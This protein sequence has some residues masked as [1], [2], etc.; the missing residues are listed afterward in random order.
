M[1]WALK[2]PLQ[3]SDQFLELK[4]CVSRGFWTSDEHEVTRALSPAVARRTHR[5]QKKRRHFW[6]G[7]AFSKSS[8]F[9]QRFLKQ[10]SSAALLSTLSQQP[11]SAAFLSSVFQQ[12]FSAVFFS[13]L[14]QQPFLAA[15]L[16]CHPQP[17]SCCGH[18]LV[19]SYCHHLAVVRGWWSAIAI[20]L[21][22][23]GVGGQLLTSSCCGQGLVASYWHNLAVVRCWWSAM[24]TFLERTLGNAFGK[25]GFSA[26]CKF[27]FSDIIL[28][29]FFPILRVANHGYIPTVLSAFSFPQK[30]PFYTALDN[31]PVVA[32]DYMG[33]PTV[34]VSACYGCLCPTYF[35]L[36]RLLPLIRLFIRLLKNSLLFCFYGQSPSDAA[37]QFSLS[38]ADWWAI[39]PGV[40]LPK[41]LWAKKLCSQGSLKGCLHGNDTQ[42]I[43]SYI[44]LNTQRWLFHRRYAGC[45]LFTL[46]LLNATWALVFFWN[47]KLPLCF[48][49]TWFYKGNTF[50][51]QG[52]L[53]GLSQVIE[54]N[55]HKAFS[56]GMQSRR[57]AV[58]KGGS[59]ND[60][61]V[62]DKVRA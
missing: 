36:I 24:N 37:P 8:V 48:W 4:I 21:L 7:A 56:L 1:C 62:L 15:F 49:E 54:L 55:A 30:H 33:L 38:F 2:R 26:N 45:L 41:Q 60:I 53:K 18:G 34:F 10:P 9:Q 39:R 17:S 31:W 42:A 20:I 32:L 27:N 52:S 57:F 47:S 12:P 5:V 22:W 25:K 13:S 19:V 14:S 43:C 59:T 44:F 58:G 40:D 23:L 50:C 29:L 3:C 51:S 61:P 28:C 16:S 35:C 46:R 11:S 6:R